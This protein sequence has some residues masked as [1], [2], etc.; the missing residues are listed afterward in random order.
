MRANAERQEQTWKIQRIGQ[1]STQ[2][3]QKKQE[4]TRPCET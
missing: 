4:V 1:M 2:L 3:D